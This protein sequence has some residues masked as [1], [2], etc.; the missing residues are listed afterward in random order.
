MVSKVCFKVGVDSRCQ[1]EFVSI[2]CLDIIYSHQ[3]ASVYIISHK[4]LDHGSYIQMPSAVLLYASST[5]Y[6]LNCT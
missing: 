6:L 3:L 2:L 1:N 4:A 5:I